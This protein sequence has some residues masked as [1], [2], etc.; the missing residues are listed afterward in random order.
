[1]KKVYVVLSIAAGLFAVSCGN[2]AGGGLM[3]GGS[4]KTF[5]DSISYVL[6]SDFGKQIMDTKKNIEEKGKLNL[7]MSMIMQG[8]SDA[9]DTTKLKFTAEESRA[10]VMRFNQTM[11][12][13]QKEADNETKGKGEKFLAENKTKEG[14]KVTP[15]GLQY[16]V[17]SSGSGG[18]SPT[19]NDTVTVHYTGTLIDGKKFDSSVDRG[20]PA[21]FPLGA[22]I[23]GW[24]EGL[25][26]MKPGDKFQLFIP[27]ELGYGE[28]GDGSGAIGGNETLIFDVELINVK[29]G[30]AGAAKP[31][32]PAKK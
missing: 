14:V 18:E 9:Q 5:E 17:V 27:S 10:I 29:K 19:V 25:S 20:Q 21:V 15:S 8:F 13:K 32:A 12:R 1:M 31:A 23:R 30:K 3:S 16:K 24:Q 28:Q 2:N 26:L 11:Q 6:G 22:V 7:N 4:P